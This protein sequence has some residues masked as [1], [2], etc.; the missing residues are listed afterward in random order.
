MTRR[1]LPI[2]IQTFRTIREQN[3]YYVDKT[4]YL[5]QLVNEGSR[6][7]LSRPRRFGKSLLLNTIEELFTGSEALFQ[8]L[9]IH[10]QWDWSV[11]HPVVSLSFGSG[12]FRRDGDLSAEVAEQLELSEHDAAIRSPPTTAAARFRSLIRTLHDHTGQRVVVL[13]D[14]YDKPILDALDI[15]EV[16]RANRNFL[17]GLY[18]VVKDC[19]KHVRFAF[20]TG[21][22][23]FS[24]GSLFSG[25]DNLTDITLNPR[26][27]AICGY[28]EIDIDNVF[29]PELD[30]LDRDDIQTWYLGYS[31]RGE[32]PVYNP[33]DILQL[34]DRREFDAWWF[35]TG[36][37]TFLVD[38]LLAR[39]ISGIDL[40]DMVASGDLLSSFDVGDMS[41]EA[42]LF[43]TGYLTITGT[44]RLGGKTLY[45]LG[46]PNR[47][48]RQ[49]LNERL[50]RAMMPDASQQG[51]RE[52]ELYR[53]MHSNDFDGLS[54]LFESFFAS[55][56]HDWHRKNDI[57]RYEGYYASVFY[58]HFAAL[59]LDVTVEDSTSRGRM[60]MAVRF[61]RQIYLFEFKLVELAPDGAAMEQLKEKRYAEK[62][63]GSGLPIHLIGVE[64]SRGEKN[65]V[66]FDVERA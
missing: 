34:F 57:A 64:F 55:I 27:A 17:R 53:L 23:N 38:T 24:K 60:D 45:R 2:G 5:R 10:D 26:Y 48:V 21:V 15:P 59:G 1:R 65:I 56:P 29:A 42:L 28:T 39:G 9:A 18:G 7:F 13:V 63:R 31:W 66:A 12:T 47:E 35:E 6:Y 3:C 8:G 37:P 62:Y 16:A 54:A 61:N 11:S 49:S 50:L 4:A 43:Q 58:A 22:S 52:I 44:E 51:T 30:G 20:L 46:Y 19:D 41:T 40:E 36:T 33:F 25:L 32:E 14:E